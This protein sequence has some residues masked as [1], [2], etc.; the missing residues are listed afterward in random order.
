VLFR[1][2]HGRVSVSN[3]KPL[4]KLVAIFI[5]P[6]MLLFVFSIIVP[7]LVA[8]WY[9]LNDWP[10]LTK[11]QWA[12]L[13]NFA[14]LIHDKL[15]WSSLWNNLK[16]ALYTLV[17]QVGIGYVMAFLLTSRLV[18]SR[19]FLRTVMF[20]PVLV[21]TVVLSFLWT[22]VYSNDY[23]MLNVVLR[24]VGLGAYANAWLSDPH[25][26]VGALAIPL[27][28]QWFGFY[29]VIFMGAIGTIPREV[30]ESAEL[31]GAVGFRKAIHISIPL[32]Y[33]A[34]VVAVLLCLSG[35]MKMFDTVLVMTDGGPGNASMV[36]A[37][38]AYRVSFRNIQ[39]GYG[40]TIAV[41]IVVVSLTITF[42]ARFLLGGKRYAR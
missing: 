30:M 12:G 26:V 27:I 9:S 25:M 6:G 7:T 13:A 39:L 41:G 29:M 35:I 2:P 28:W 5:L 14:E 20:F 33:D 15:F 18:T 4:G 3:R 22:L 32:T 8:L 23:G 37:L 16:L 31:D 19:D 38:Y 24:G 17:G 21:S 11:P 42:L 10:T 40:N 36:L 34:V 1:S